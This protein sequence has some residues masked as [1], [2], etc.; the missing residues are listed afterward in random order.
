MGASF[1]D[2]LCGMGRQRFMDVGCRLLFLYL[3]GEKV[4][5][6]EVRDQRSGCTGINGMHAGTHREKT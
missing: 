6:R 4:A 3:V 5:L 2:V 1:V